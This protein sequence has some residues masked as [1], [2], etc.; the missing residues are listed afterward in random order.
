M[1]S[2]T[3][4]SPDASIPSPTLPQNFQ[5]NENENAENGENPFTNLN[6]PYYRDSVPSHPNSE[7]EEQKEILII[8]T[9][10]TL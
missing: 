4:H 5:D 6:L 2:N 1:V 8:Q 3:D 10:L 7:A 9:V